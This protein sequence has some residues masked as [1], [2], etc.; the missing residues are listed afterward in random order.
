AAPMFAK[1][2]RAPLELMRA[3]AG[4]HGFIDALVGALA[5]HR[6]EPRAEAWV[7]LG[8]KSFVALYPWYGGDDGGSQEGPRYFHGAAMLA[9]LNTLDVFRSAFGLKLEDHNPWFRNNPYFLLY[10]Y[11]PDSL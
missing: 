4:Q 5:I 8:F 9:S 10:S 11:P 6:D 7:E 1:M 2:R 3:H